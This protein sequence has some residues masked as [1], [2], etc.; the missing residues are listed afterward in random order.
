MWIH[1]C[2]NKN[3]AAIRMKECMTSFHFRNL[4]SIMT[5]NGN[6]EEPFT[7]SKTKL[8]YFII[9]VVLCCFCSYTRGC[10]GICQDHLYSKQLKWSSPGCVLLPY[11]RPCNPI[12]FLQPVPSL[13]MNLLQELLAWK[14]T[15]RFGLVGWKTLSTVRES[16]ADFDLARNLWL[17]S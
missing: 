15:V 8:Q 17:G 12:L 5:E 1:K 13:V 14:L 7:S 4:C 9:T 16:F 6:T 10:P 2:F 3:S 11:S